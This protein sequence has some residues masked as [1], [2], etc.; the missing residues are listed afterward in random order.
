M[1]LAAIMAVSALSVS[2]MAAET[3]DETDVERVKV[4]EENADGSISEYTIEVDIPENA[5]E[6]EKKDIIFNTACSTMNDGISLYG[7]DGTPVLTKTRREIVGNTGGDNGSLIGEFRSLYT[8]GSIGFLFTEISNVKWFNVS[9]TN[10]ALTEDQDGYKWFKTG[11]VAS[12]IDATED[13]YDAVVWYA[14]DLAPSEAGWNGSNLDINKDD[15]YS[16]S[17]SC[18]KNSVNRSSYAAVTVYQRPY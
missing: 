1:G 14:H 15:H 6:S 5:S 7:V 12:N 10:T 9:L 13:D 16:V 8:R 4:Y 2:A 17:V 11:I 3:A 18:E